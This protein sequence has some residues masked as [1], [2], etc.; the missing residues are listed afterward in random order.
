M[1][2]RGPTNGALG[3]LLH[4]IRASYWSLP[5]LATV[6]ALPVAYAC[7][8]LDRSG[9]AAKLVANGR[10][11][12]PS[13]G[14]AQ[15]LA[16]TVVGINVALLTLY[17]SIT[18]LVLTIATANLGVRLIDRWLDRR[19]IRMSLAGLCFNLLFSLVVLAAIDPDADLAALPHG[20][21]WLLLVLEVVNVVML[22]A[23]LHDLGRT[24]F[25][26]RAIAHLSD[27]AAGTVMN[28]VGVPP[29][30]GPFAQRV[31]AH[32]SGYV[33]SI[34]LALLCA[35]MKDHPGAIRIC[36]M[37]GA[38]VIQGEPVA[39]LEE[40]DGDLD[41]IRRAVV[42]GAFRS[43]SQG[44]VFQI[45]LVVEIAARALSPAVN[46]FF[47]ALTCADR[48]ADSMCAHATL[49]LPDN[50]VAACAA[51]PRIELPGQDFRGWYDEPLK[52]FR[53]A[54]ASYPSVA[55]RMIENYAR[56]AALAANRG[57]TAFLEGHAQALADHASA[58]ATFDGDKAD[59]R[60]A[61]GRFA[62]PPVDS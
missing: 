45:R 14:S 8:A 16:S 9:L 29:F 50:Q 18:L 15:E 11:L 58:M 40:P 28:I 31:T 46:D 41:A 37:P 30:P 34:D 21:I 5:L 6:V 42:I 10:E 12:V 43:D 32:R 44:A 39:L 48:L 57:L 61:I 22:A 38:H 3:W 36:A 56:V 35:R 1:T 4:R 49:W 13:A 62:D 26:D 17:F 2:K 51:D 23:A 47:T 59:I 25:V 27:D 60:A 7:L 52:A 33:E 54:A 53:E 24:I 19:F 55:V 20:T